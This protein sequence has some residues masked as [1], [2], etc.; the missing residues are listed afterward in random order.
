MTV[1]ED[2]SE[3]MEEKITARLDGTCCDSSV[4][5]TCKRKKK[6][7]RRCWAL[8]TLTPQWNEDG[9]TWYIHH[10]ILSKLH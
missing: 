3:F 4:C 9:K 6:D 8:N 2:I 1:E 5:L 10:K 7:I